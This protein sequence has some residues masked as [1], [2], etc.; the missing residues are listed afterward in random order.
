MEIEIP[1]RTLGILAV[2]MVLGIVVLIGQQVTPQPPTILWPGV[3]RL[4]QYRS[5]TDRWVGEMR[6]VESEMTAYLQQPS[7]DLLGAL[8]Q[9]QNW[10]A[11]LKQLQDSI[12]RTTP[13]TVAQNRH[14]ALLELVQA[15]RQAAVAIM[16]Y[17]DEPTSNRL[18]AAQQALD[19]ARQQREHFQNVYFSHDQ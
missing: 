11:R 19:A 18:D 7:D 13:P 2:V 16:G 8:Q 3:W 15:Y 12:E 9:V 5:Q 10:D 17:L 14:T 4:V 6:K 1:R